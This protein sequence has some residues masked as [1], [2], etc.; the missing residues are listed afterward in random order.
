MLSRLA[1]SGMAIAYISHRIPE[2][3]EISSNVTILRD[4]RQVL[5][6]PIADLTPQEVIDNMVGR[7][8]KED[9]QTHRDATP[10][11]VVLRATDIEAPRVNSVMIKARPSVRRSSGT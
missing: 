4:G 8:L 5:T 11:E 6:A 1:D 7:E 2:V 3:F 10:G 9:L